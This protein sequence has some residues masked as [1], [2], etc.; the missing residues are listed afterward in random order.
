MSGLLVATL[1][2]LALAG[3]GPRPSLDDRPHLTQAPAD[4]Q[5]VR[6]VV[7]GDTGVVHGAESK[8]CRDGSVSSCALS[9]AESE[10]LWA[11]IGA[12]AA[13]A[14]FLPGDLV[15]G[16]HYIES[17]PRCRSPD[18]RV[19]AEWL[20][21][22]L[23]DKVRELGVPVY[24]ALGNHDVAHRQRSRARERCLLA[25][26]ASEPALVLPQLQYSV[27][28]GLVRLVVLDT[29][30]A[31]DRWDPDWLAGQRADAT[32]TL[33]GG[34]HV[35]QTRFDKE[36]EHAIRDWLVAHDLRPHL[37]LNGHAHFLQFG[38]YD[39]I[40]AV[41]SGTGAKVR[42]RPDCPGPACTGPGAPA[43][44]RSTFGY[45]VVDATPDTLT[46]TFKDRTGAPLY[47][48]VRTPSDPRGETCPA[49]R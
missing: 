8:P 35:V 29:N 47:C 11:T 7:V 6:L 39:G 2:S 27:D 21:P 14:L 12:E 15:Y 20:D 46:V 10:A 32:W 33:M 48:W 36:S 22:A 9:Q 42:L 30:V 31:P 40:P 18:G 34:H 28:L 38:V 19:R 17:A 4:P 24:L 37:W 1:G 3:A 45:A 44:S 49:A 23:G 13:D 5:H 26:A 41:T 16:P 43:F 25:Y